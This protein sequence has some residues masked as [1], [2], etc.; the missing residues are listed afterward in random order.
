MNDNKK[1]NELKRL[2]ALLVRN[3]AQIK[4]KILVLSNKGGVGK[5]AV[6]VN[7]AVCLSK[8]GAKVGLLDAD[9]HGPSI[10]K[11]FGIEGEKLRPASS[12][13]APFPV[14]PNLGMVSMVFIDKSIRGE[15]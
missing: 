8:K 3:M 14:N 5:S 7:M 12:G 1:E 4:A 10:V 9:I 15:I 11:M 6:A 13:L 2:E